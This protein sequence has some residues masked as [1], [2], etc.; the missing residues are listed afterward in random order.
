MATEDLNPAAGRPTVAEAAP[1]AYLASMLRISSDPT[2]QATHPGS[3]QATLVESLREL[4]KLLGNHDLEF[5]HRTLTESIRFSSILDAVSEPSWSR[6]LDLIVLQMILPRIHGSRP[7]VEPVLIAL[8][9]YC[10][11]VGLPDGGASSGLPLSLSKVRRM[12]RLVR[13]NQFVSFTE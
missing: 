12:L 13:A 11:E 9:T 5:G 1:L 7:R 6:A 8:E 4:H 2:W 3:N 10:T